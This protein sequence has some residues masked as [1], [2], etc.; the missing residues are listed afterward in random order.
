MWDVLHKIPHTES[1][2]VCVSKCMCVCVCVCMYGW[3]PSMDLERSRH[4]EKM[5]GVWPACNISSGWREQKG[6]SCTDL[7]RD[8]QS[9]RRVLVWAR[10]I[11]RLSLTCASHC[12]LSSPLGR[13]VDHCFFKEPR[14]RSLGWIYSDQ[15][16]MAKCVLCKTAS[17]TLHDGETD[18]ACVYTLLLHRPH[19]KIRAMNIHSPL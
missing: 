6:N 1:V 19:G 5:L 2:C 10:L 9:A 3:T 18:R 11:I 12:D 16:R 7:I 13:N 15:W 8:P 14:V 4:P 17:I